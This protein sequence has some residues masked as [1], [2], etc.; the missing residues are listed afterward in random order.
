M[1]KEQKDKT[2]EPEQKEEEKLPEPEKDKPDDTDPRSIKEGKQFFKKMQDTSGLTKLLEQTKKHYDK[3]YKTIQ[4]KR[5]DLKKTQK[6]DQNNLDD[7][8]TKFEQEKF[9]LEG[10]LGY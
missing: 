5:K 10:E 8:F 1:E 2:P 6:V 4:L 3:E 7:C 9:L